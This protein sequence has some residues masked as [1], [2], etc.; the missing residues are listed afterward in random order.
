MNHDRVAEAYDGEFGDEFKEETR[1]RCDWIAAKTGSA[2]RVLDIGC[3]QGIV[4]I[5]V[6]RTGSSVL[7]IDNEPS[8]IDY[9][10]L[11]KQKLDTAT[12]GRVDFVCED[13]L[14]HDF[15]SARFDCVIASEVLEHV[16]SPDLMLR[17]AV[18]LL[19]AEGKLI[20]TVPFGINP[21]P[22]HKRTYYFLEMFESL[23]ALLPVS[24]VVF[25]GKWIGFV[26]DRNAKKTVTINK[27][28]VARLE[29]GFFE[30]D[31]A[32]LRAFED[33]SAKSGKIQRRLEACTQDCLRAKEEGEKLKAQLAESQKTAAQQAGD[34]KAKLVKQTEKREA[35]EAECLRAKSSLKEVTFIAR[36]YQE[37]YRKVLRSR[38]VK[39]WLRARRLLGKR[40]KPYHY[41][42]PPLG[43]RVAADSGKSVNASGV[44][45]AETSLSA[46]T[47]FVE[48]FERK[49]L[50]AA[51]SI[52]ESNGSS[53]FEK[54]PLRAGIV[55]DEFMYNYY[56]DALDFVYLSPEGYRAAIDEGDLAFVMFVSCW[57]GLGD[58]TDYNSQGK[59]AK[60]CDIFDY[61]RSKGIP[62]L[63]Q[64]IEDPTNYEMFLPIAKKAD[65]IF[66]SDANMVERYRS[67]T[68]NSNVRVLEYGVNP[69]IHNPVGFLKRHFIARGRF[70]DAV[71]F[72]GSWYKRYPMRCED[73]SV[74]FDGVLDWA[75]KDLVIADRNSALPPEKRKDYE[76]PEKYKPCCVDAIDHTLLQRVH[77]LFDF[78][79]SLST[80]KDSDTMCAMRVYEMQAL[81]CLMLSNY[82]LSIS[83]H[84]PSV[85]M[86]SQPREVELILSGYTHQEL[87][88]LQ[89]EGVRRMFESCTVYHRLNAVFEAAKI[90]FCFAD[91][92]VAIVCTSEE[93]R[94]RV[95]QL[96]ERQTFQ[97][98]EVCDESSVWGDDRSRFGYVVYAGEDDLRDPHYIEDAVNA[99]KFTDSAYVNYG[100]G[101]LS[102]TS[103]E[104]V[105]GT[106]TEK[107]T[108]YD[109]SKI[110]SR[111][112]IFDPA[113]RGAL[114]GF[115]L[116]PTRWGRVTA[117]EEKEL[118]VIVPVYNN[119]RYL[120]D[121]CFLSLLRSSIFDAMTIY[122]VDDGSSDTETLET[123]ESLAS[124]YDN[125]VTYRFKDGGSGS[126]SRPR[127]KGLELCKEPYVTYLDPDNEAVNDGY[128]VLLEHAKREG[129]D[130][131]VGTILKIA[132]PAYRAVELSPSYSEGR[133]ENPRELLLSGG[134]KGQSVQACVI[135]RD[136]LVS[137]G[138]QNVVG[139][140]GQDTLFYYEMMLNASS[141]YHVRMPIHIYY[142]ERAGS[143]VNKI[144]RSFFDK[145]LLLEKQQVKVLKKHGVLDAYKNIKLDAFMKGWYEEKLAHVVP[146]DREYGEGA[147][148][149][150]R[151]LYR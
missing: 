124:D 8:S 26:A 120:R 91:K 50:E 18:S 71:F 73:C 69:L 131:A 28:L 115:E 149:E 82:A 64:T 114:T 41:E 127:N 54:A 148:F 100:L 138:I 51:R 17:K 143:A 19:S 36:R 53:Y 46:S 145:S 49:G 126:A 1:V 128:A 96:A 98:V 70:R 57:R 133:N 147:I 66:T 67:D 89:I 137:S 94:Q 97:G 55:T 14:N 99:F 83:S 74:L 110:S 52:A 43:S 45:A 101:R 80:V 23:S 42:I 10:N 37:E 20:V 61:A 35:Y 87:I 144:S 150:I 119:G 33:A 86:V 5:L 151:S 39:L 11:L 102:R 104:S 65:V 60:V 95:C 76:Y 90:D 68:G 78:C 140:I 48:A 12:Q 108:I 125:V 117:G 81:G 62:A 27:D 122:L 134:F 142:A 132:A 116:V 29:S 77:K 21:H 32:R 72:A 103:Y 59:R 3:S 139:A 121:R 34:L 4:S 84:F 107:G 85:F 58:G 24:E 136:F 79:V 113:K 30:V 6:A 22:D 105:H 106:A 9:A 7:G 13:F 123:I 25:F 130:F 111:D 109:L 15:G 93:E 88:N 112:D 16:F 135:R 44:C 146:E 75:L 63:F 31:G 2:A 38:G 56:K 40:Y 47:R 118:G 92:K 141:F 129:V